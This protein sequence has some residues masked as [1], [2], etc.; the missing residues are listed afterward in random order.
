MRAAT[1]EVSQAL[2]QELRARPGCVSAV[3]EPV[4]QTEHGHHLLVGVERGAQGR[5][6]VDTQVAPEP[7]DCAQLAVATGPNALLTASSR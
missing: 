4:I 6:L 7:D 1:V 3:Q 2:E 5:V